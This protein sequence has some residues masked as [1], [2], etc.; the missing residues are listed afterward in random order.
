MEDTNELPE[1]NPETTQ[2]EKDHVP[3]VLGAVV[4]FM[5]GL[6][7]G[8]GL[9][10]IGEPDWKKLFQE[11]T[12]NN[13]ALVTGYDRTFHVY[14]KANDDLAKWCSDNPEEARKKLSGYP[15]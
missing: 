11:Q 3:L 2:P 6:I 10:H 12:A 9:S 5:F 14:Q 8:S 15:K 1:H 4:I 7:A 13:A